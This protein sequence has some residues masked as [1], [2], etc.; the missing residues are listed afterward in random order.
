M[1]LRPEDKVPGT[2]AVGVVHHC[3]ESAE[4]VG[5]KPGMRIAVMMQPNGSNA[6]YFSVPSS[7]VMAVPRHLDACDVACVTTSYLPAFQALHHGRDR[8]YRYSK[9]C[10][11]GC[12]VFVVGGDQLVAQATV[13]LAQL[14]GAKNVYISGPKCIKAA[15]QRHTA[16]VL[17]DDP[18]EWPEEVF[19]SM[20]VIIDYQFPGRFEEVAKAMAPKSRLVCCTPEN[21]N[22]RE[23]K[24]LWSD[25]HHFTECLFL[26][27]IKRATLFDFQESYRANKYELKE[28]LQFLLT[29]LSRRHIR[30]QIDRYV[31]LGDVPK[32]Y[33]ELR[34]TPPTGSIVCEPWRE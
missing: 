6:R 22:R 27:S 5:I 2:N 3:S 1:Q 21:W 34:K 23:A 10:L 12:R 4:E 17:D 32:V 18:S 33:Q 14:A 13:R 29:A 25:L 30:P 9:I 24:D 26:S 16:F 8:P 19:G 20:D 15:L 7:E 31:M 11:E 28:D